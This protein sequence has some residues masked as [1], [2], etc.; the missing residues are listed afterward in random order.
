MLATGGTT[1]TTNKILVAKKYQEQLDA[2]DYDLFK[3]EKPDEQ[4][5]WKAHIV[6][7]KGTDDQNTK[8]DQFTP[9]LAYEY[10]V[11]KIDGANSEIKPTDAQVKATA[12]ALTAA[13]ASAKDT[14]PTKFATYLDAKFTGGDTQFYKSVDKARLLQGVTTEDFFN[15]G[16]LE[17]HLPGDVASITI[18]AYKPK[19]N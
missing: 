18:S 3:S 1:T 10:Y 11:C 14:D 7:L 8:F 15:T 16:A 13:I 17:S 9:C 6:Q 19:N 4:A 12:D 5:R 2:V